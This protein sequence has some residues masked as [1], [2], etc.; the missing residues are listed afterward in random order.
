MVVE[1]Y[2]LGEVGLDQKSE[3]NREK[4]IINILCKRKVGYMRIWRV[5]SESK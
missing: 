2:G 5:E 4:V 3:R 1:G